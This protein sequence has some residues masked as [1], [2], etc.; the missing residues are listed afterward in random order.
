[1]IL[2]TLIKE[3]SK[4]E[5]GFVWSHLKTNNDQCDV[6]FQA[7]ALR[8]ELRS[9]EQRLSKAKEQA[10]DYKAAN[11]MLQ[12]EKKKADKAKAE[13]TELREKMDLMKNHRVR[14]QRIST[15]SQQ[16]TTPGRS[17]KN[18]QQNISLAKQAALISI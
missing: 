1:M 17:R 11:S 3:I 13:A 6:F 7:T 12:G 9:V 4:A 15:R 10:L 2:K 5:L 14:R 16:Q 8:E 18:V